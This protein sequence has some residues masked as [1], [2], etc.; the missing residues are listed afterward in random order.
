MATKRPSGKIDI[1]SVSRLRTIASIRKGNG[2]AC[3]R[4]LV[5]NL[6]NAE[7]R[8]AGQTPLLGEAPELGDP[9]LYEMANRI[10]VSV[11]EK[12]S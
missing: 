4:A 7:A 9:S 5:G 1:S 3:A 10:K 2:Y 8:S 11:G 12:A 6:G